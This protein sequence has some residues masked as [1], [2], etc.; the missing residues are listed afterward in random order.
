MLINK[1]WA[2]CS[3]LFSVCNKCVIFHKISVSSTSAILSTMMTFSYPD[4]C[5]FVGCFTICC[6]W[7]LYSLY[8]TLVMVFLSHFAPVFAVLYCWTFSVFC[9]FGC[10]STHC[11]YVFCWST[12][13]DSFCTGICSSCSISG[14]FICPFGA[15]CSIFSSYLHL[16]KKLGRLISMELLSHPE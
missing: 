12:S 15:S 9:T 1:W 13:F 11:F 14:C 6:L 5:G 4:E 8:W 2:N 10:S 16:V 3:E 7:C